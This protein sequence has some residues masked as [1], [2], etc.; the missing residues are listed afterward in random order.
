M[1]QKFKVKSC[2]SNQLKRYPCPPA[3]VAREISSRSFFNCVH[4]VSPY[5][6][7]NPASV[8][9]AFFDLL[10]GKHRWRSALS[11]ADTTGLRDGKHRFIRLSNRFQSIKLIPQNQQVT[12]IH[13][14]NLRFQSIKTKFVSTNKHG[15]WK[16]RLNFLHLHTHRFT[17]S[18]LS[19]N[20]RCAGIP[21]LAQ[22]KS[23][24]DVANF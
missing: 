21:R 15:S 4:G 20:F 16:F 10:S 19:N 5:L 17:L 8:A 11:V 7:S 22:P 13:G 2:G 23:I 3:S 24:A 9:K 1:L 12:E 6:A 14:W 18:H